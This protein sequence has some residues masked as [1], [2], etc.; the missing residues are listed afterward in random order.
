MTDHE[1]RPLAELAGNDP[2]RVQLAADMTRIREVQEQQAVD[3]KEMRGLLEIWRA[4]KGAVRVLAWI[5]VVM[6]WIGAV[7][8]GAGLLYAGVRGAL[9]LIAAAD[10]R[11]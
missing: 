1:H 3:I 11:S 10:A 4:G 7:G 6:K 2:F 5:G 9:H 8:V